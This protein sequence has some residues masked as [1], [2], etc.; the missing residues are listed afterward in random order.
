MTYPKTS[1]LEREL[2]THLRENA[3][4]NARA[5]AATVVVVSEAIRAEAADAVVDRLMGRRPARILHLRGFAEEGYRSWSAAR[6]SMDRASRGVCFE[7]IYLESPDDSAYESRIWAPF[8]VR[9]LPALLFWT[10][11]PKRLSS[12]DFDCADRVDLTFV[13][14]SADI[15]YF[16]TAIDS[17][18][19]ASLAAVE[20]TSGFADLAWE[21]TLPIR[22]AA[23]RLFEGDDRGADLESLDAVAIRAGDEWS[24]TLLK[25]WIESRLGKWAKEID[26]DVVA[27]GGPVSLSFSLKHHREASAVFRDA[28]RA[29]LHFAD[30]LALEV[31]FPAPDDGLSLARLVDAPLAD[32]LFVETLRTLV[33]Y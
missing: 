7:D 11:G 15:A 31:S 21:R 8:V 18:A 29:E 17:Y 3:S 13:D 9:E 27:S 10:I 30:G 2:L 12:C 4:G 5:M 32:P 26:F 23:S 33:K 6:C 16:G 28:K 24:A 1:D 20:G 25:G 19:A 22:L 14:G